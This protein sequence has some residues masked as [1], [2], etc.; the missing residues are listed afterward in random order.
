[1]DLSTWDSTRSTAGEQLAAL[2]K[3]RGDDDQATARDGLFAQEL[4]RV[5]LLMRELNSQEDSVRARDALQAQ[6]PEG[7]ACLGTGGLGRLLAVLSD[8]MTVF[9][10]YCGCDEGQALQEAVAWA[11]EG[12]DAE[13]R[14][15]QERAEQERAAIRERELMAR[16]GIDQR[17]SICTFDSFRELLI[18]R[19]ALRRDVDAALTAM[20]E[21]Y[22]RGTPLRGDWIWGDPG[23]GKTSLQTSMARALIGRG[24]SCIVMHYG[25]LLEQLRLAFGRR[26][27]SGDEVLERIRKAPIFFLDDFLMVEASRYEMGRVTNLLVARHAAGNRLLTGVTSNYSMKQASE[28]MTADDPVAAKRME[29]RFREMCDEIRLR[30]IDLRTGL[31]EHVVS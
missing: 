20:E 25:D 18:S 2:E 23:H 11:N 3:Q 27:G 1:M 21:S 26:D 28:R 22:T 15:E 9:E 7:C 29:G 17:Y 8:G 30:T 31:R 4:S 10:R 13:D 24:R 14:A 19:N 6:R 12:V 5:R 16:A